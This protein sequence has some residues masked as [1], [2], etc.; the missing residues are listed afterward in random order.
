MEG[1]REAFIKNFNPDVAVRIEALTKS[2][3]A[4]TIE[5]EI[6]SFLAKKYSLYWDT[7]NHTIYFEAKR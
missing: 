1:M 5:A 4:D 2:R 3:R 7:E 6:H